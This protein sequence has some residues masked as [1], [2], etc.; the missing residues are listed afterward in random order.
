MMKAT[1]ILRA[2]HEGILTMLAVLDALA[3]RAER[4]GLERADAEQALDFFRGFADRCH[5]GKEERQ[6][7]PALAAAGLG[8]EG[9]PISVMLAEH[10]QGR[11]QVKAM[12]GALADMAAGGPDA[13]ASFAASA[14]NYR[15]ILAGHIDKENGVL[16]PMADR[17]LAKAEDGRLAAEFDRIEAEEMGL[18]THERYHAM[19]D[20]MA[21]RYTAAQEHACH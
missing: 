8:E 3:D 2:E 12:A 13:G 20:E 9:G 16:F 4:G 19:I 5:H 11:A 21:G 14:R 17:L 15:R 7:F 1:R 18:G 6:L 10:E